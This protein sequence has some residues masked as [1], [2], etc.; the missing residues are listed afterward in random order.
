MLI[1]NVVSFM[2]FLFVE[3]VRRVVS[4][5]PSHPTVLTY[6][7]SVLEEV[8]QGGETEDEKKAAKNEK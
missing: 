4:V 6:W 2:L 7:T 5:L 3:V 1:C 8:E